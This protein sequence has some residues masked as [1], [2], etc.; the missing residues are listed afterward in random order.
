MACPMEERSTSGATIRTVPNSDATSASAAIP[1]LYTP[2]SFETRIRMKLERLQTDGQLSHKW[3]RATWAGPNLEWLRTDE[4]AAGS[5]VRVT[6]FYNEDAGDG[7]SPDEIRGVVERHGHELVNVVSKVAEAERLLEEPSDLVVAAGGDGTVSAVAR[8]VAAGAGVPLA[9]LPLGT[10]NNIASSL[11]HTGSI[12]Q[13]INGWKTAGRRP[14]D[15][16]IARGSWGEICFLEAVGAGL[17]ATGIEAMDAAPGDR[18]ESPD[19][20]LSRALRAFRDVL[21][22][23]EPR[24]WTVRLDGAPMVGDFLLVE[25]LN[26]RSVGPNLVLSHDANPSDGLFSIVVAGEEHRDELDG[27]LRH[28]MMGRECRLSLPTWTARHVEVDG[29]ELIHVDDEIRRSAPS[30]TTAIHIKPAALQVLA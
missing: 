20:K 13:L 26:I 3:Q 27:Y 15:L 16:G 21:S 24:R 4:R 29:P 19:S 11:G 14:L 9:I 23:L 7:V 22:R 2:S 30:A 18:E 12:P 8:R 6:V 5:N 17:I 28:R 1:G 25:V 10:A